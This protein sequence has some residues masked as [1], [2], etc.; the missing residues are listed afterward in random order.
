M[1]APP[2]LKRNQLQTFRA[3]SQEEFDHVAT[4]AARLTVAVC[5]LLGAV[6]IGSRSHLLKAPGVVGEG[7][8]AVVT[9]S[10]GVG[11]GVIS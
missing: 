7:S 4:G 5:F 11:A 2:N 10:Q 1:D 8:R 9:H 6:A 3:Q